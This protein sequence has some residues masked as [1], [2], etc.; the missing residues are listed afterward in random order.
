[1]LFRAIVPYAQSKLRIKEGITK[2]QRLEGL[3]RKAAC[4]KRTSNN[5]VE[6]VLLDGQQ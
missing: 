1:M 6:S 2:E 3:K 4:E 5:Y